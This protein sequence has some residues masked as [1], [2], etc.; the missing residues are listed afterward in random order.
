MV[1]P[2]PGLRG[3]PASGSG[4]ATP[5]PHPRNPG[6]PPGRIG[7]EK[8]SL[9]GSRR[10]ENSRGVQV[11]ERGKREGRVWETEGCVRA[12]RR[13]RASWGA[14]GGQAT[15]VP[16]GC[17]GVVV[18]SRGT[19]ASPPSSSSRPLRTVCSRAA[20]TAPPP[21]PHHQHLL[22]PGPHPARPQVRPRRP[23]GQP[24]AAAALGR[25]LPF[26]RLSQPLTH[27][28]V[29]PLPAAPS[30]A[31]P[32]PHPAQAAGLGHQFRPLEVAA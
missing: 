18:C 31:T 7:G 1:R 6:R 28:R 29:P 24:A 9:P 23:G 21:P 26:A 14:G 17:G 15:V 11:G 20:H 10:E 27:L 19:S 25:G 3:V 22:S 2:G 30:P 12:G 4:G 32:P 16:G 5:P 13:R 8:A